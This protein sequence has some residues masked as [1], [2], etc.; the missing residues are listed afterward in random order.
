LSQWKVAIDDETKGGIREALAVCDS[1]RMN[2][3]KS[4]T[5]TVNMEGNDRLVKSGDGSIEKRRVVF[6]EEKESRVG[7]EII[8]GVNWTNDRKIQK[9]Q[10]GKKQVFQGS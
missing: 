7:R 8:G 10:P 5:W 3:R 1:K 9:C 6:G 4:E 2:E